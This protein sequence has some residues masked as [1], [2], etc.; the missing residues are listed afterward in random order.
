MARGARQKSATGIYHIM[1]RGIDKRDIFI[2]EM[3]YKKFLQY[4]EKAKKKVD[5]RVYAYCLMNNH[6]HLLLKTEGEEIGNIV[7]RITVG[8]VQYHNSKNARTG[9]LF[10]NRFRSE[11]VEDDSYFITVLRYI[12]QNPLKAGIVKDIGAYR[13]SSYNEY[14]KGSNLLDIQFPLS[15]FKDIND[16]EKYM[17]EENKNECLEYKAI[18]KY[19][20]DSLKNY[21]LLIQRLKS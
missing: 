2:G 7:R 17:K 1:V 12:H 11:V 16:F 20:D 14:L 9:H 10:Q 8:Y 13:W 18:N 21:L 15:L 3:D 5:F 19:T 6:A 4:I